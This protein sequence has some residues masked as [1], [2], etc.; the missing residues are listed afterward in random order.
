MQPLPKIDVHGLNSEQALNL[1]RFNLYDFYKR[2]F[3][4]VYIIHGHGK[5]IL[6]T[7]IRK[8]LKNLSYVKK[9]KKA[10][11]NEGGDGVTIVVF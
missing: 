4:E 5:G 10:H 6:K 3:N 7:K 9:L 1:I 2:G 11:N 8:M